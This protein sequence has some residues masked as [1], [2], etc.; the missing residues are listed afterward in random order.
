MIFLIAGRPKSGKTFE[1][2]KYHII[3]AVKAGRKVITNVTLDIE[4]F[5]NVFGEH[6]RDLIVIVDFRYNDYGAKSGAQ[7]YFSKPEHYMDEWRNEKGQGPLYVVDEAQFPMG[8]GRTTQ[9]LKDFYTMHG[10]YGI[11]ILL[12]SQQPRQIDLDVLGLIEIVYRTI[13]RTALGSDKTYTK[14]V[15][16]GWR[17]EVVN[18]EARSYEKSI[19]PFYKAHSQSAKSVIEAAAADVKPIWSHWSFKGCAF[20]MV[21]FVA[22]IMSFD[23]N[24]LK[25]PAVDASEPRSEVQ[26]SPPVTASVP[27]V[28]TTAPEFAQQKPPAQTE[29]KKEKEPKPPAHPYHK[30][31]LHIVG[32]TEFGPSDRPTTS[33]NFSASRNGQHLF[34]LASKE[35]YL[36]GYNM[37]VIN[38]CLVHLSY[39][40]FEEYIVCDSPTVGPSLGG[41]DLALTE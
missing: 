26:Q 38:P 36:A 34:D 25:A 22:M 6:V 40:K 21:I 4:H 28:K 29:E 41:Q 14:K 10:H 18:T 11:D 31:K 23:V 19:F 30:I 35:L 7:F 13:K 2:V 27:Q 24:P 1:A 37:T 33:V 12:M 17:G 15:Q 5:V 3:P 20:M 39:E 8:K 9:E 32:M 16:D